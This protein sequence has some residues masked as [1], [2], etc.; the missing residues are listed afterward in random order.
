MKRYIKTASERHKYSYT[1]DAQFEY[2]PDKYKTIKLTDFR[3]TAVSRA[4]ALN[5][6][7]HNVRKGQHLLKTAIV[8]LDPLKLTDLSLYHT[9]PRCGRQLNDRG[10]CLICDLGAEDM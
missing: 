2:S 3:T 6:I 8:M 5:N 4:Q 1:G 9:C 7:K 10:E